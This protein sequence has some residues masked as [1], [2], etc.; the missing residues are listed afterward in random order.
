MEKWCEKQTICGNCRNWR[1][2]AFQSD[3]D[4]AEPN[5]AGG[6]HTNGEVSDCLAHAPAR[7]PDASDLSGNAVWPTTKKRDRCGDFTPR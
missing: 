7:N 2:G 5:G 1:L 6:H 3:F 4:G